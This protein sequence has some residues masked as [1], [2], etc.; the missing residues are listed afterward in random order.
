MGRTLTLPRG[1]DD[2][3]EAVRRVRRAPR[4]PPSHAGGTHARPE[5]S[6]SQDGP[7]QARGSQLPQNK[8]PSGL[9]TRRDGQRG[10]A[11]GHKGA[12]TTKCWWKEVT[13][14]CDGAAR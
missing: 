9:E 11:R 7:A 4:L 14:L 8:C 3:P 2:S 10:F 6:K 12:L 1:A 13:E 5:P